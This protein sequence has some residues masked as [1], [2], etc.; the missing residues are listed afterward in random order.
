[1]N[2]F[3]K[4]VTE[5]KVQGWIEVTGRRGRRRKH[6]LVDLKKKRG[7]CNLNEETLCRTVW[8]TRFGRGY[9]VLRQQNE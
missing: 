2:R 3:L 7:Y 4:R 6:L 8:G 9:G 1:M 5:R